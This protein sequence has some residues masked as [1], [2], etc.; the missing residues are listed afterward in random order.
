MKVRRTFVAASGICNEGVTV[1]SSA[2]REIHEGLSVCLLHIAPP[3]LK[4]AVGETEFLE[5][6]HV[7]HEGSMTVVRSKHT[8]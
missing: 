4:V 1:R 3:T 8:D 2:S 7:P 5:G 6:L